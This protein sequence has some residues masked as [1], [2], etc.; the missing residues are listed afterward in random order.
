MSWTERNLAVQGYCLS[1]EES[2]ALRWGLR[3]PTAVCLVLVATGVVLQSAIVILALVPIGAVAGWTSR[4]PFDLLWNHGVRHLS[5][6]PEL[7]PN[8]A[9]RR[10]GFKVGT[11][12]LL[13]VGLLFAG[14]LTT[15]ATILGA[16]LLT[17]CGLLTVTNFCIP[18]TLLDVWWRRRG[19]STPTDV[20]AT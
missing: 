19:T 12:W 16:M 13:I 10:H 20:P 6:A 1:S 7:P 17:A 11:A 9:P 15:A 2:R 3:L 4:H 8:P 18:S 14:G 5:G